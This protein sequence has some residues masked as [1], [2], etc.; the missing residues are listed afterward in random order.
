MKSDADIK[1][2]A[3]ELPDFPMT[4][5]WTAELFSRN[6][7]HPQKGHRYGYGGCRMIAISGTFKTS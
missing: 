2:D 6:S 7:A 1:I 5:T 3:P 4:F